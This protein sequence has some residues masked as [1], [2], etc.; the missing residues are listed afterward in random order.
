MIWGRLLGV[1]FGYLLGGFLGGLI[2]YFLGSQLDRQVHLVPGGGRVRQIQTTFFSATFS[3]MGHLCKADGRVTQHEIEM[4]RS[5][6]RQMQL[7][8][9]QTRQ[10]QGFFRE[11]KSADFSLEQTLQGLRQACRFQPMLLRNFVEI[12][13]LAAYADGHVDPTERQILESICLHLGFSQTDFA[14]LEQAVKAHVHA[15]SQQAS[16]GMELSDAYAILGVSEQASDA[17]VK[18][19]YRRQMS[20]HHPDKLVSQGLPEEMMKL[21]VEKSQEIQKAYEIIQKA[22]RRK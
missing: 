9:E 4:A 13:L 7:N 15:A 5:I 11:G 19:A 2:G 16:G 18:K 3:V 17:E 10:A 22:R 1:V 21:A 6:M 14:Q 8:P 12:Q 20:Q